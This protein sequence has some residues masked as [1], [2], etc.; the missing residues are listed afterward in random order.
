MVAHIL[1]PCVMLA[2]CCCS[3]AQ[4]WLPADGFQSPAALEQLAARAEAAAARAAPGTSIRPETLCYR[5]RALGMTGWVTQTLATAGADVLALRQAGAIAGQRQVEESRVDAISLRPLHFRRERSASAMQTR[6]DR[7]DW[8]WLG[9]RL[10]AEG[11][12]LAENGSGRTLYRRVEALADFQA[13]SAIDP[14]DAVFLYRHAALAADGAPPERKY[15]L[16][17]GND[18]LYIAA[19]K[20]VGPPAAARH[21]ALGQCSLASIEV[22]LTRKT[23]KAE[24]S[25]R[26][27]IDLALDKQAIPVKYDGVW[28]KVP[29]ELILISA[30]Y[31]GEP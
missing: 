14:L 23:S 20:P 5:M 19:F 12:N 29:F 31:F 22:V 6:M 7:K 9:L 15:V 25:G 3:A 24:T 26:V 8:D 27:R 1:L 13:E 28:R 2:C 21:P 30:Q 4:D 18:E 16:L 10:F 17:E 11:A